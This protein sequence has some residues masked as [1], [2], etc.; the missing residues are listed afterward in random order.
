[1][2]GTYAVSERGEIRFVHPSVIDF[3]NGPDRDGGCRGRSEHR[4]IES[5]AL[6]GR[7]LLGV[8]E[9]GKSEAIGARDVVWIQQDACRH[10]GAGQAAA[11]G[12][13]GATDKTGAERAVEL[14]QRSS[15][16]A[17]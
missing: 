12:L 7:S 10:Q 16:G 5:L 1:M 3:V 15:R 11:A 4:R 6:G 9:A 8:V 17:G 13:V 2:Q 14:E